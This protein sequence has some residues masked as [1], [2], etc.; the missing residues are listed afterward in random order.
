MSTIGQEITLEDVLSLI[1][2]S[3]GFDFTGYKRS[4]L[5]RRIAKRMGEV[6]SEGYEAYYQHLELHPD[7]FA[8]LFNTIL[9]N[10]TGFYRD[11][12]TWEFLAN[13]VVPEILAHRPA[14]APLRVW[15]AGVASGEEAYTIAM[16]LVGALG[17]QTFRER[18]KIYATDADEE[19]LDQARAGSYPPKAVE[20]LPREALETFFE[21]TDQRYQFRKDLRRS[22]IF[23]RNDL[24][25]DA[26]ISRIDLL[27][28]RNTLMYFNAETQQRILRRFHFGLDP[29]GVLMLGKSEMLLSHR[30]LFAPVDLKRRIFRKV[31]RS[32]LRDRM[33]GVTHDSKQAGKPSE[34]ALRNSAFDLSPG[35]QIVVD[36]DG[37]LMLA[38]ESA[39]RLFGLGANDMDRP[40]AEL[41]ISYRPVELGPHLERVFT[42]EGGAE[43]QS[44]PWRSTT[45]QDRHLDV[46]IVPISSNGAVTG[47]IVA[48]ADVT[49]TRRLSD[50]LAGA[51]RELDDAHEELQSAV[52]E[53]ETTNEELQS[54]N[55]ELETTNE[56]LQSTNEELET[57]NEELQ[58]TN[59]E[60]E[61]MNEELRERSVE[62]N[63]VN[64]FLETILT[65]MGM[66]VAVLDTHL[67]VQIWNGQSREL[68][69][70]T[71]DEVE[72]TSFLR[73]DF[74]LPV[75][76]LKPGLKAC[77]AGTTEREE[78]VL[79][80][81]NRRGK[82]FRCGVVCQPLDGPGAP[83]GVIVMMEPR[84]D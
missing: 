72:G 32:T 37:I 48:Y 35:A 64:A 7:E 60:L 31:G 8:Q 53:L 62:L 43:L 36:R 75:D 23:G 81:V 51:Q 68:W 58:S 70:L 47:A 73:L 22:V 29:D 46:R 45:A 11:P 15:C 44:V 2:T 63:D 49:D 18:V 39:R 71:R 34:I 10:V 30:D 16:V 1:K 6:G 82:A 56:E 78:L 38:N 12:A 66:S 54:T 20:S 79:D 57:T 59:E 41:E 17:E 3:R 74:G 33:Q 28:C 24:V 76:A 50:Q 13:D 65:G 14:D 26:P 19:A 61:T 77:L 80:A 21:R 25:Q 84:E 67:Q 40:V 4:T 55:E 83:S 9:I 52:E 5:E 42:E 69:G 27:I